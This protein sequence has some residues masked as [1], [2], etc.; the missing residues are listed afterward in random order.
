LRAIIAAGKFHGADPDRLLEDDD[1][2][3]DAVRRDSVAVD[4]LALLGEPFD[5]GGGIGDLAA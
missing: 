3:V 4:P 5:E 1:P 2:L